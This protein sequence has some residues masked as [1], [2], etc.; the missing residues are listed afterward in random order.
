[1]IPCG[2]NH[3]FSLFLSLYVIMGIFSCLHTNL[4]K[5]E[6]SNLG[7]DSY[8]VKA[9]LWNK[10]QKLLMFSYFPFQHRDLSTPCS[11]KQSFFHFPVSTPIATP[12]ALLFTPIFYPVSRVFLHSNPRPSLDLPA[13]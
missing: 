12:I 2:C 4:G 6:V 5:I 13:C 11:I 1:M 3:Q 10:D 9:L 8:R 7:F